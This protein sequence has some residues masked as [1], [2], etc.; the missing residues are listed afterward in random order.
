MI[1]YPVYIPSKGR[2]EI[3]QTPAALK[4]LGVPYKLVVDSSEA[5]AYAQRWG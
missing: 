2:A 1:R 3:A 5:E 4:L